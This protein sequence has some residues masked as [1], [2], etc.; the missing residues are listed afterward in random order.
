MFCPKCGH[1]IPDGVLY[2]PACG[3][4]VRSRRVLWILLGLV[5]VILVAA[6]GRFGWRY[7]QDSLKSPVEGVS[8]EVYTEGMEYLRLM[9]TATAKEIVMDYVAKHPK[10]PWNEMPGHIRE[11]DFSLQLGKHPTEQEVYYD[12]VIQKFWQSSV[13]CYGHAEV[14]SGY[15]EEDNGIIQ[16]TLAVY[17]G[18]VSDFREGITEAKEV[19]HSARTMKDLREAY[20]ILDDI[21]EGDDE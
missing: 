11:I 21:W 6:A 20:R 17:K 3:R 10:E 8:Y 13:V 12:K 2:C 4:K 14:I 7:Y 19:Q 15:E 18:I 1:E 5:A 16:M 9:E